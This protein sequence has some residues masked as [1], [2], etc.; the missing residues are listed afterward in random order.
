MV[1]N[2]EDLSA[3]TR[4]L[5]PSQTCDRDDDVESRVAD[6]SG[7]PYPVKLLSCIR[8]LAGGR[9]MSHVQAVVGVDV[10]N[11]WYAAVNVLC[12]RQTICLAWVISQGS[13]C[14]AK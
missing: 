4:A 10:E 12:V 13:P 14:V 6:T 1:T 3:L 8:N 9:D 5:W 2:L 7:V 11:T